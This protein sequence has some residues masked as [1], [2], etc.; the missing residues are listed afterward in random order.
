MRPPLLLSPVRTS[1]NRPA[2]FSPRSR[3]FELARPDGL[4]GVP[5]QLRFKGSPVPGSAS[6]RAV[7]ALRDVRL[8]VE[9]LQRVVLGPG[10]EPA[11]VGIARGALG[12]SPRGEHAIDLEPKVVVEAARAVAVD[13]EPAA[14]AGRIR[15]SWL[16]GAGGGPSR[17]VPARVPAPA[18]A[19]VRS[20][21]SR[22][23]D[24]AASWVSAPRPCND[25][26]QGKPAEDG[27]QR[28]Q[29]ARRG[30]DRYAVPG[31]ASGAGAEGCAEPS[32]REG[33]EAER[34]EGVGNGGAVTHEPTAGEAPG[35]RCKERGE[36]AAPRAERARREACATRG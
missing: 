2:S 36:L 15:A 22:D 19:C 18:R 14:A 13:D 8:E 23:T 20:C 32:G 12:E 24:R 16:T 27:Q 10:S 31:I 7:L 3:S 26:L 34:S 29:L 4:A 25:D 35:G 30:N 11:L 21:A 5:G 9:V 1:V 6:S 17:A 33:T 28:R